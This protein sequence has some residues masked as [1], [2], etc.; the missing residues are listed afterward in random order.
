[1]LVRPVL[2]VHDALINYF[3]IE[4]IFDLNAFYN[5][6]FEKYLFD[7]CGVRYK[8][9]VDYGVD[10]YNVA[11]VTNVDKDTI[12]ISGKN[13]AICGLLT[14]LK[15]ANYPFEILDQVVD[16]YE[17][18]FGSSIEKHNSIRSRF[19]VYD[20]DFTENSV[21]IRRLEGPRYYVPTYE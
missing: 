12:N 4:M 15:D 7:K 8:F 11:T 5:H 1:M 21:T 19:C 18:H 2:A 10:Y 16:P 13:S 6:N 3:K 14:E 9:S 20:D 17:V